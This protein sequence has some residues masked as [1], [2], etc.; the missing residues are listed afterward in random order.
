ME[1]FYRD[2][3]FAVGVHERVTLS[4]AYGVSVEAHLLPFAEVLRANPR[5]AYVGIIGPNA[6]PP[7]P[8]LRA[9]MMAPFREIECPLAVLIF[10]QTGFRGAV[11]RS[12]ITAMARLGRVQFPVLTA[13]SIESA[14]TIVE[15]RGLCHD[16]SV[17]AHTVYDPFLRHDEA[18]A[19]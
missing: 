8:P 3:S 1:V 16:F 12:V 4:I 2:E 11:S 5:N 18:A 6:P 17:A 19:R 9:K 14:A 10:L 15:K 7:S 13:S